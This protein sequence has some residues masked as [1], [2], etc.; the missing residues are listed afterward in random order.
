MTTEQKKIYLA[1]L[2]KAKAE[3]AMELQ[4]NGFEKSQIKILSF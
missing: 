2:K 3:V 1:Y 4:T